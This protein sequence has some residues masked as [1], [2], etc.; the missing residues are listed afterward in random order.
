METCRFLEPGR[1]IPAGQT[2]SST[3]TTV[4]ILGH[5]SA[6]CC[7]FTEVDK[8]LDYICTMSKQWIKSWRNPFATASWIHLLLARSHPFD[9]GN[10][11]IARIIASIPLVKAGYPPISLTLR[12][13]HSYYAG[14]QQ[15]YDG[16]HSLFIECLV[17]C[18]RDSIKYVQAITA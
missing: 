12:Q 18:M 10:G 6:H 4:Q 9:D 1:Y 17:E 13:Q 14:T 5:Y 15:A 2:R 7:P 16:D 3:K 8:E 11:R